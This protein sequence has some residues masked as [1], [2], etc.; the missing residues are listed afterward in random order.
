METSYRDMETDDIAEYVLRKKHIM[1]SRGI[2]I[3]KL[4]LDK[5]HFLPESHIK[6]M[7]AMLHAVRIL[8]G[9]TI[10]VSEAYSSVECN[11]TYYCSTLHFRTY[12]NMKSAY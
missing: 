4:M 6:Y 2:S 7:L 12:N 11:S 5:S 1:R 9:M 10:Q 3:E 8:R